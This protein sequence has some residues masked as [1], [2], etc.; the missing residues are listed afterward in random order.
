[1]LFAR[2]VKQISEFFGFVFRQF[3]G[4]KAKGANAEA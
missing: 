1:M 4:A 3:N 2:D